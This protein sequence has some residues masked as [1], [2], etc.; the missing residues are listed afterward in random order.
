MSDDKK[1]QEVENKL[2]DAIEAAKLFHPIGTM[3]V[4]GY[5]D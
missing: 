3:Y 2:Q 1:V 5:T 4:N